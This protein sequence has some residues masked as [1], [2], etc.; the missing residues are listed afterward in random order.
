MMYKH[1]RCKI[2]NQAFDYEMQKVNNLLREKLNVDISNY[3]WDNVWEK[4]SSDMSL[5]HRII[6]H[7]LF[8]MDEKNRLTSYKSKVK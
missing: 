4:V 2:F 1:N 8:R 6:A 7:T 3:L 5:M